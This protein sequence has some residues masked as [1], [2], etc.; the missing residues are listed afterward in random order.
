M[1]AYSLENALRSVFRSLMAFIAFPED[2]SNRQKGA[3]PMRDD[4]GGS[5]G[6]GRYVRQFGSEPR[7]KMPDLFPESVRL[8][9]TSPESLIA[10]P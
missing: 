8:N 2:T 3:V 9:T 7:R 5:Y 4:P 1:E 10:R 6:T